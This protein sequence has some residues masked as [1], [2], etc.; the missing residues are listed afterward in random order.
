MARGALLLCLVLFL[1]PAFGENLL[2]IYKQAQARDPRLAAA[3]AAYEAGREKK[4]QGESYLL[5]SVSAT[6]A[7]T[8]NRAG[9]H[10]YDNGEYGINL[11]HPLYRQ[12][13]FAL[14]KQGVSQAEQAEEQ[15]ALARSDLM[16]RVAQAYFEVLAAQDNLALSAAEVAA[17]NEQWQQATAMFRG[18]MAAITD[19]N[20]AK[21]R[22]DLARAREAAA[23][24]E[25]QLKQQALR[26][27]TGKPPDKL[28]SLRPRV[29]LPEPEPNDIEQWV[30]RSAR[31][32]LRVTAQL[33]ALDV[34]QWEV[35]RAR[36]GHYPTLDL[37]LGYGNTRNTGTALTDIGTETATRNV[38]LQFQFPIFQ[39]GRVDSR[40]REAEANHERTRQEL[41]D[42][43]LEAQTLARQSFLALTN[44]I[45]Q[46][47]ALEQAVLS[48]EST[49]ESSKEGF[50]VG[51]RN[52]VDVLNAEQ[53]LFNAK[54][55]LSRARYDY[56]IALL[57]L[58]DAAGPL[59][60]EHLA[61]INAL[62]AEEEPGIFPVRDPTPL[63]PLGP[64]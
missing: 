42:A 43:R 31:E 6:G 32:N 37:V 39:G 12:E 30:A 8:A 11:T 61:A 36:A 62:V 29:T 48:S 10:T 50:T 20:E 24:S 7:Y 63:F 47:Q 21:A 38:A 5:P 14:Y 3:R 56:V 44:G 23:Q 15:F 33:K 52:R 19:V 60:E 4:A 22:Y 16:L 17:L 2:D 54:R 64:N 25:F 58:K 45:V 53:Q 13:N 41:E 49:L 35:E 55:D 28:A 34:A 27:L 26:R 59:A 57:K 46:I 1:K 40:V 18:G 51:V 9:S